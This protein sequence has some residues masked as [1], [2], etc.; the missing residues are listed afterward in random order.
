M[1]ANRLPKS[2]Q[3]EAIFIGLWIR[4]FNLL[5]LPRISKAPR[6]AD[7]FLEIKFMAKAN[8][9]R[10][11]LPLIVALGVTAC[12]S[13]PSV[14]FTGKDKADNEAVYNADG[15]YIGEATQSAMLNAVAAPRQCFAPENQSGAPIRFNRESIIDQPNLVKR[16]MQKVP[17]R[18][19]G[20]RNF[21]CAA[22]AYAVDERGRVTDIATLYNSHPGIGGVNFAREARKTLKQW[23]YQPGQVDKA[24]AKFT[25]LS[26]VFYYEFKK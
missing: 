23:R 6:L 4:L 15:R 22:F 8:T 25:G 12:S 16:E 24:P 3:T 21:Y 10:L 5:R 7:L 20:D 18:P 17:P 11:V 26:T 1:C 2:K 14:P 19:V 9:I 13:M